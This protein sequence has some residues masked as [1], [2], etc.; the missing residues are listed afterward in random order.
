MAE[1]L[2]TPKSQD[3][4]NLLT[5]LTGKSRAEVIEARRCM[6]CTGTAETFRD[7]LSVKEYTIS[8]MCQKCQDSVFDVGDIYDNDPIN[9]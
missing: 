7:T 5:A 2:P 6:T 8:G 9:L 4:D 1:L 3:I